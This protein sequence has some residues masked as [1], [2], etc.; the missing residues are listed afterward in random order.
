[1]KRDRASASRTSDWG[2]WTEDRAAEV[3]RL[4]KELAESRTRERK[5]LR[6][7]RE[8]RERFDRLLKASGRFARTLREQRSQRFASRQRLA[9]QHAINGILAEAEDLTDAT[10]GILKAL[11]GNLGWR[12]CIFWRMDEDAGVLRRAKVWQR[13]GFPDRFEAA[14]RAEVLPRGVGL[15]GRAWAENRYVWTGGSIWDDGSG[16]DVGKVEGVGGDLAFPVN[17]ENRPVAV[18]ELLGGD[19]PQ[20]GKELLYTVDLIGRQ[21]GQFVE[22]RRVE[23][24]RERLSQR[25]AA[26]RTLLVSVLRQMPAGVFIAEPSGEFILGNETAKHIY[27]RQVTSIDECGRNASSYPD[28]GEIPREDYPLVRSLKHG[29][30]VT[31]MEHYVHRP[32]GT[33]LTVSANSAPVKD[34]AGRIVAAVKSFVDV[35]DLKEAER[36]LRESEERFRAVANLVPDLLWSN[37]VNGV[38]HWFNLRWLEYTGQTLEEATG[39]GWL[40]AVHPDDRERSLKNFQ[41]AI[42]TGQPLQQEHRVRRHDGEY[43]WFLVRARP[44]KSENGEILRWFGAA[45]DVHEE[46]AFREALRESERKYRTL[47]ESIDEGFCIVEMLFDENDKPVD[48]RFLEVNPAFERHTG[49]EDALGKTMRELEPDHEE[50]W[51]E[52]YGRIA[53]TGEPERFTSEAK[54][55]D[56]RWFDVYGFR[57]GAPEERRVAILFR[58]ITERRKAEEERLRLRALEA[59]ARAEVSER[60]RISRE[61]HDRV[62]HSMGV[63]HQSLQ[64][65]SVLAERDPDRA[66]GKLRQAREM[67]RRSLE[68]TRNLSMEIRRSETEEGLVPALRDLLEVAVPDDIVTKLSVSGEESLLGDRQRG[69][70]YLMLREAIRNAVKHSGCGRISVRLEITAEEFSGCVEDDGIGLDSRENGETRNGGL[71]LRSIKERAAILEGTVALYSSGECSTGVRIRVPLFRG[72]RGEVGRR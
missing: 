22:R 4:R 57:I 20:P 1:M 55:L 56:D 31:G 27:G 46:H 47:F 21:I 41:D 15:P 6:E 7:A 54:Y 65:Y 2:V 53:R 58:D 60:E 5:A 13:N 26:E 70:I 38:S 45:T 32:N 44:L 30:I 62:A 34:E 67:T 63:A 10:E 51:F 43:R 19:E 11:G 71:G 17:A 3:E 12:A 23:E 33:R 37:G 42:G 25:V 14:R 29:E 35:T 9:A 16:G 69:Q 59:A 66:E 49:L 48:Y 40:D 36:S 24:Q 28:G 39:Y 50:H 72:G 52:I 68:Q 64:L 8:S 61:L 18:I